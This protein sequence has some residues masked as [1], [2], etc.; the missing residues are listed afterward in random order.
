MLIIFIESLFTCD[1][2]LMCSCRSMSFS[3]R[4]FPTNSGL[5]RCTNSSTKYPSL[6]TLVLISLVSSVHLSNVTSSLETDLSSSL[7]WS[8]TT[9]STTSTWSSKWPMCG[10]GETTR[11]MALERTGCGDA[12]EFA[13]LL[14]GNKPFLLLLNLDHRA[15]LDSDWYL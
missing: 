11:V 14:K 15:D 10:Q 4:I 3:R 9:E 5:V 6:N 8:I 7:T 13:A 1:M 2:C 12:D